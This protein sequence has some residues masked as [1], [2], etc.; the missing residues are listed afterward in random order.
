MEGLACTRT[1][2]VARLQSV[3]ALVAARVGVERIRSKL[4]GE[5][6]GVFG[7]FRHAI[8]TEKTKA[9]LNNHA[10]VR[11]PERTVG[12]GGCAPNEQGHDSC[13]EELFLFL[14]HSSPRD[15]CISFQTKTMQSTVCLFTCLLGSSARTASTRPC[16]L[17]VWCPFDQYSPV[18]HPAFTAVFRARVKTSP[19]PVL[20]RSR[21]AK[22]RRV[23]TSMYEFP[24]LTPPTPTKATTARSTTPISRTGITYSV[25]TSI[26]QNRGVGGQG[27]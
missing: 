26:S 18:Y 2:T 3:G 5:V 19:V 4:V 24:T 10:I 1:A 11:A 6:D 13:N 21:Q 15:G 12:H 7:R 22:D 23:S 16:L 17:Y 25:C 14:H 8:L 27:W 9:F 20:D